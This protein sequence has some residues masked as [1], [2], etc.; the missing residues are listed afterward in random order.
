MSCTE[1]R[2]ES[3]FTLGAIALAFLIGGCASRPPTETQPVGVDSGSYD[4]DADRELASF[5]SALGSMNQ[6]QLN[7]AA[8]RFRAIA[9]SR[10][11]LAGPWAN[12]AIVDIRQGRLDEAAKNAAEALKRNPRLAQAHGVLGYVSATQ[13]DVRKALEHYRRAVEVKK[14][15]AVAH[16]NI[17]LISD[18]YLNDMATAA[19]HYRLYLS[20]TDGSD[21]KTADWLAEIERGLGQPK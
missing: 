10:P 18:L 1:R 16:Y 9:K 5:Q 19:R 2:Y 11:E 21:K 3:A 6:N 20:A 15:Y 7:E 14:D 4:V 8:N 17:A 13:G 12:L